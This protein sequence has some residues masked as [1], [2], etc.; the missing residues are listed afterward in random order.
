MEIWEV[1]NTK[2]SVTRGGCV[3]TSHKEYYSKNQAMETFPF[4][5]E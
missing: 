1:E 3:E 5:K 2:I 4:Q